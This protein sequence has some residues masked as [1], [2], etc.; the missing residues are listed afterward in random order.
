MKAEYDFG[1]GE[2]GAIV[3]ASAGKTRITIRLDNDIIDWFRGQV[4]SKGGGN[5]QTMINNALRNYMSS[6]GEVFEEIIRRV[7]KEEIGKVAY[8][9][10]LIHSPGGTAVSEGIRRDIPNFKAGPSAHSSGY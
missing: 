7:I 10:V 5:Y 6:R 3:P 9:E 4:E 1:K 8:Q 2:R